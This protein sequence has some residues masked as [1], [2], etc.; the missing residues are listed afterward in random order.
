MHKS[1]VLSHK[2]HQKSSQPISIQGDTFWSHALCPN[3]GK[4]PKFDKKVMVTSTFHQN[5]RNWNTNIFVEGPKILQSF[6]DGLISIISIIR[7]N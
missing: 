3:M 6:L 4:I 5:V 7:D 1:T 2:N